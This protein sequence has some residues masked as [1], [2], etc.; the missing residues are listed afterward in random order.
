MSTADN[1]SYSDA[2][3]LSIPLQSLDTSVPNRNLYPKTDRPT[4]GI[5]DKHV[6]TPAYKLL[7]YSDADAANSNI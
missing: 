4:D 5:G 3:T 7:Y 1:P 6:P 2:S